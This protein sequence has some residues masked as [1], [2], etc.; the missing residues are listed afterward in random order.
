MHNINIDELI[1]VPN[2]SPKKNT[3][4]MNV[5]VLKPEM[6]YINRNARCDTLLVFTKDY[7]G[8]FLRKMYNEEDD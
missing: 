4:Q 7:F 2:V 5:I 3:N 1:I 8:S 6:I